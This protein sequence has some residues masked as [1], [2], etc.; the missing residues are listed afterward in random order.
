MRI[1]ADFPFSED[2]GVLLPPAPVR[3]QAFLQLACHTRGFQK[4][5]SL[6]GQVFPHPEPLSGFWSPGSQQRRVT[7]QEAKHGRFTGVISAG[8]NSTYRQSPQAEAA[9]GTTDTKAGLGGGVL[10]RKWLWKVLLKIQ[11]QLWCSEIQTEN[12]TKPTH[13]YMY[14]YYIYVRVCIYIYIKLQNKSPRN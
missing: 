5:T 14:I 1:H 7:H 13:K 9:P 12:C 4:K 11:G 6:Y 3:T 8:D 10:L 2:G